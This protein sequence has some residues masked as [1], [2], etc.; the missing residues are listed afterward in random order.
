MDIVKRRE[1][2]LGKLDGLKE[3]AIREADLKESPNKADMKKALEVVLNH[4]RSLKRKIYGGFA[5][6]VAI[7]AKSPK[8]RIYDEFTFPDIDFYSPQPLEDVKALCA[9]LI[10]VGYKEVSAKTQPLVRFSNFNW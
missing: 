7:A 9:S 10:E 4:V 2:I 3:R 8:D 5:I 6:D 1:K